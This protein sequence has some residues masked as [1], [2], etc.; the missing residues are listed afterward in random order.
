MKKFTVQ[1]LVIL[2]FL[3][4]FSV[5]A[6]CEQSKQLDMYLIA[7]QSNA[8]GYTPHKNQSTKRYENVWYA[9][10]TDKQFVSDKQDSGFSNLFSFDAYYPS[11]QV[12][13]GTN[14]NY[15]GPEFGMAKV[16]NDKYQEETKAF[17][18]K[19]GAGGTSIHGTAKSVYGNWYPKSLWPEGYTPNITIPSPDNDPMGILYHLF[20]ENFRLVY[21]TLKEQGYKPVVK[22]IAWMQGEQDLS[23]S[24]LMHYR[25]T[26][27]TFVTDIRADLAEI[28]GDKKLKTT[29]F[30]IGKISPSFWNWNNQF[31]PAM[32][33]AQD[34]VAE[35]LENVRTISVSDLYITDENDEPIGPDRCHYS[36]KDMVTLGERFGNAL[37]EMKSD[38]S[39]L[40][41]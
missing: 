4:S 37:L 19:T 25:E 1:L 10:M 13:C 26:L 2:L 15:M 30:V 20:V 32:D 34:M 36:F 22:G 6:G 9:G 5:F 38:S 21:N 8:C 14:A 3:M 23:L 16:F 18:F 33:M 7:G 28:T 27:S 31:V 12:G 41:F 40:W 29:P 17:I 39:F 11:V 35:E 24:G